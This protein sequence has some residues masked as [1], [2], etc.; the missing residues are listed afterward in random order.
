MKSKILCRVISKMRYI[1]V[2]L[3]DKIA[4]PRFPQRGLFYPLEKCFP[5][6]PLIHR[7]LLPGKIYFV[8]NN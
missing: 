7:T 3:W 5:A 8:K 2:L 6:E 4:R 1:I